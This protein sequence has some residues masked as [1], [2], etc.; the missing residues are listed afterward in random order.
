ME[1]TS[2]VLKNCYAS[3]GWRNSSETKP[4]RGG[5]VVVEIVG[6]FVV[7]GSISGLVGWSTPGVYF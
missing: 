1:T 6:E 5:L 4:P 2:I 3:F 7:R